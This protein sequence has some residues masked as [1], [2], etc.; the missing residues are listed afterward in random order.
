[1]QK[2]MMH[3]RG[4]HNHKQSSFIFMSI[5][6]VFIFINFVDRYFSILLLIPLLFTA[7]FD[8]HHREEGIGP[9]WMLMDRSNGVKI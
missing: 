3:Q 1:M 7:I 6:I 2:M 5:F 8:V 4:H 9:V